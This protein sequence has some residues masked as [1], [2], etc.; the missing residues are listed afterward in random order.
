MFG[1]TD[2]YTS[3]SYLILIFFAPPCRNNNIE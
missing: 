2:I 3:N 1:G